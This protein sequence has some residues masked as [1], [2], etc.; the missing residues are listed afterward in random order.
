M[1]QLRFVKKPTASL[2]AIVCSAIAV[3][4]LV[5]SCLAQST[6]YDDAPILYS[7]T[8]S[9]DPVAL[10]SRQIELGNT[11]LT[12]D[13]QHG[14]LPALLEQLSIPASSQLLVFSKT[15]LQTRHITPTNPRALYFN[16][17]VYIGVVPGDPQIEIAAVDPQL[18]AVFYTL[19]AKAQTNDGEL[20]LLKRDS[21]GCLSCHSTSKTQKV[22]GFL[23]RS[24]FPDS[25]GQP[26]FELGTTTTDVSTDFIDRFGGWYITGTHG[27]MRHRGNLFVADDAADFEHDDPKQQ[28]ANQVGLPARIRQGKYV[29][30]SSDIVAMMVLEHQAQM[31]NAI[32]KASYT[33]REAMAYQTTM[34]KALDREQDY[35]SD[36]TKRRISAA[37]DNVVKHLLFAEEFQLQSPVAGTSSF[38]QD[39]QSNREEDSQERSL[40]EFDLKTRL[41]RYPCSYLIYSESFDA[42]PPEILEQ[43]YGRLVVVL[44]GEPE[45]GFKHLSDG[46]RTAILEILRDTKP[47]FATIA[48]LSTMP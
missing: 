26:R 25:R 15:S 7:Q 44:S 12:W 27:Q 24:V 34:N 45:E 13:Q 4:L 46:D 2:F 42:L 40:R 18:G 39:F 22:P 33:Y 30:E 47:R 31:H 35:K 10:L 21:H 36:S 29:A 3:F 48:G 20:P 41:F 8:E 14:W 17:N 19:Y 43:I 11:S 23:I 37:A 6:D 38:T 1:F 32:T 28:G 9:R 5:D 16:D